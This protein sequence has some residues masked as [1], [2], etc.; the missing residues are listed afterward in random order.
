MTV[1]KV[2][3]TICPNDDKMIY[4]WYGI[5]S[6]APKD[7][8]L[9]EN[10]S[11]ITVEINSPGGDVFSGSEIYTALK[12]YKGKV[13]VEIVGIAASAASVIAM[14]GDEVHISPTAQMMIHNASGRI[15]GNADD[16]KH[17]AG[18]LDGISE[19]IA[20]SYARRT[21]RPVEDFAKLMD[22]ETWFTAK[23]A[24]EAGLADDVMFDEQPAFVAGIGVLS[25][26]AK[27]KARQLIAQ[28][29][30]AKPEPEPK[31]IDNH[32]PEDHKRIFLF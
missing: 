15:S 20:E 28:E 25:E 29:N 14:A 10:G 22:A 27:N 24:V 23:T 30:S 12:K 16:M 13:S 18:I 32:K 4:S 8:V 21:G 19:S 26:E 1:I 9:P 3:G 11:D 17:E 2:N 6:T 7:I 5:D 31:N